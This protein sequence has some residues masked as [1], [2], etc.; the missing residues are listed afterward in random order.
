MIDWNQDGSLM[1]GNEGFK[2]EDEK[3]PSSEKKDDAKEKAK[4][5]LKEMFYDF[6][7]KL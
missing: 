7:E 3:K 1:L 4:D 2:L 5:E 6:I